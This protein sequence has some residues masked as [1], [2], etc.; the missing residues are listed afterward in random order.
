[1]LVPN[2]SVILGIQLS[3]RE[4]SHQT[5]QTDQTLRHSLC[6]G[7]WETKTFWDSGARRGTQNTDPLTES[8]QISVKLPD[9]VV[10][11]VLFK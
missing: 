8:Y 6:L 2:P 11:T 7:P 4:D 3:L 5:D 1:M 9:S 10:S